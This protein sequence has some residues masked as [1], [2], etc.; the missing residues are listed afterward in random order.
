MRAPPPAAGDGRAVLPRRTAGKSREEPLPREALG[1]GADGRA[2]ERR[3]P[4]FVERGGERLDRVSADQH[5][6][7]AVT[8][9]LAR[10]AGRRAR[11]PAR[12]RPAPRPARCR[13]L[14]SPAAA[15]RPPAV[16][17]ANLARRRASRGT[18]RPARPALEPRLLR[19]APDDRQRRAKPPARL[20]RH[21]EALVRHQRGHDEELASRGTACGRAVEG[22]VDRRIH[23]GRPAIIVSADPP[24]NIARIRDDSGR[25]GPPSPRSQRASPA[26]TGRSTPARQPPR[27]AP[28]RSRRRTGPRRSASA[29]GSSRRARA[30]AGRTTDFTAQWLVLMTR[31]YRS[32]SNSSM[33]AGKSG[34]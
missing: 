4:A 2:V 34:R 9:R 28:G 30:A 8:H 11:R 17:L 7:H 27:P 14:R 26:R 12:R 31:S 20:D 32:R 6:G 23:N 16:E 5:A 3:A 21:V 19:A 1:I 25:P 13:S 18:A 10:A 22:C 29:S 33:A 24:R 15:P